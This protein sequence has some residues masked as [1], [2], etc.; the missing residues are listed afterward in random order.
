VG[1]GPR[2]LGFLLA[3][4][5]ILLTAC[6]T[7]STAAPRVSSS[8]A[9]SLSASGQAQTGFKTPAEAAIDT[10]NRYQAGQNPAGPT[11]S[12]GSCQPTQQKPCL[13]GGQVTTG[14]HAAYARFAV[15][16]T[17]GGAACWA[18]VYEDARG[19]HG[20]NAVCTQNSGYAPDIGPGHIVTVPGAC[21]NV[22]DHAGLSGHIMTCLPDGTSIELDSAP[23]F[24]DDDPNSIGPIH[25]RLWWHI[26]GKGWVA[27][28]LIDHYQDTSQGQ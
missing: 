21:A 11:Y 9:T 20:R 23:T 19:W 10:I 27:H 12:S 5:A 28:E 26:K 24:I 4:G 18:Y 14:V 2:V 13:T 1:G 8:A 25:G 6:G 16:A 7:S 17:A 15:V 3:G 22:R